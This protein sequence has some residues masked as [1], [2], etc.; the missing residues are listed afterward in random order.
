MTNRAELLANGKVSQTVS[1][2]DQ[3]QFTSA[4]VPNL[5]FGENINTSSSED[6]D[7]IDSTEDDESI[8]NF[9]EECKN[10]IDEIE[11]TTPSLVFDFSQP[12]PVPSNDDKKNLAFMQL[13]QEFGISHRAHKRILLERFLGIKADR[14]DICIRGCMQFSNENDIACVKCGEARYK[15]GQT[16][17]SDTRVPVRSIVQL[18]LARQLAL[19][20]ADDKTR[21]EMLYCHNH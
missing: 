12:L 10:V 1:L 19:C 3:S 6:I 20:L 7:I 16:S 13:I 11:G 5:A 18:P 2:S 21:A 4:M 17:K 8:Y 15:N 9:G 14:Y